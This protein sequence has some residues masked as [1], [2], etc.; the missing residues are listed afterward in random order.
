MNATA[1]WVA[2]LFGGVLFLLPASG[3]AQELPRIRSTQ[4]VRVVTLQYTNPHIEG[5]IVRM[6][7][8]SV[9]LMPDYDPAQRLWLSTSSLQSIEARMPHPHRTQRIVRSTVTG[10]VIG[11]LAALGLF[12]VVRIC[13]VDE[14]CG[15][16]PTRDFLKATG[17]GFAAGSI[18]GGSIG[19]LASPGH[20]QVIWRRST[21]N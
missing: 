16:R 21:E 8:D 1:L 17:I 7:T 11:G 18:L 19:L 10:G 14:V 13:D 9:Q 2:L 15:S 5:R 4:H 20:W 6:E 12:T 3:V